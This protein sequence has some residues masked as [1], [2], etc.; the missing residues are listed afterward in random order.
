MR[1]PPAALQTTFEDSKVDY[2]KEAHTQYNNLKIGQTQ[3]PLWDRAFKIRLTSK[4]TG[5]K[6]DLNVTYRLKEP[7]NG[8]ST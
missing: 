4:K 3:D 8:S 7:F 1:M 6:I 5:N 2:T